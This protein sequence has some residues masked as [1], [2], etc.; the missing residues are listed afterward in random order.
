MAIGGTDA[1]EWE[2]ERRRTA[3]GARTWLRTK[4]NSIEGGTSEVQLNIIAKRV[5]GCRAHEDEQCRSSS[6]NN[7]HAP[8]RAR[9]TFLPSGA[10]RTFA[11]AARQHDARRLLARAVEGDSPRMGF[12]GVLVPEEHGGLGLGYVDAGLD[13]RRDRPQSDAIAASC[14]R[15]LLGVSAL[16]RGGRPAQKRSLLPQHRRRRS[17]DG[18]GCRRARRARTAAASHSRRSVP[19]MAS[20]SS[21]TKHSVVDGHVADLLIVAART[22]GAPANATGS[23][24]S[25][26]PPRQR[27]RHRAHGDGRQPQRRAAHASTTWRSMPT[28]VHRR[29]R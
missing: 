26:R 15:R 1:L 2:G 10:R 8:R 4:A 12:A 19:A 27:R 24:C 21:G 16:L 28:R 25:C 23:R 29:R 9:E 20:S 3:I 7:R 5:L 11:Q 18:A 6:T 13:H 17:A 22:A 14:R